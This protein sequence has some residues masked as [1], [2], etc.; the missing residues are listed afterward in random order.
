M[1]DPGAD[2]PIN[3]TFYP[4]P[5]TSTEPPDWYDTTGSGYHRDD[6]YPAP[7]IL[8]DADQDEVD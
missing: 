6:D 8:V 7:T 4:E 5:D 1:N 2:Y 3:A